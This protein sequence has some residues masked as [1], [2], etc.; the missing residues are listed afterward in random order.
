MQGRVCGVEEGIFS[1][2]PRIKSTGCH[3]QAWQ[4]AAGPRFNNRVTSLP[5]GI[6][7]FQA[8]MVMGQCDRLRSGVLHSIIVVAKTKEVL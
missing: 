4:D 5:A 3:L 1:L 7:Y 8:S 6:G 2:F